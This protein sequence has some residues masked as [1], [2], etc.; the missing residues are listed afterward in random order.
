MNPPVTEPATLPPVTALPD[1]PLVRAQVTFDESPPR[2]NGA[3]PVR[4]VARRV[5]ADDRPDVAHTADETFREP[6]FVTLMT[7]SSDARPTHVRRRGITT[8][9]PNDAA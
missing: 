8:I 6:A 4:L 9:V 7:H 3:E 5:E 2:L 1:E